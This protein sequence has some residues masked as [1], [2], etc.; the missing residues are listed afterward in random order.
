MGMPHARLIP[1]K[2]K[3]IYELNNDEDFSF[4]KIVKLGKLA[5]CFHFLFILIM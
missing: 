2:E 4:V 1:L 3:E 5:M